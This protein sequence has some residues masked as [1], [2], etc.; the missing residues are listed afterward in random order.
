M[1]LQNESFVAEKERESEQKYKEYD[2][3]SQTLTCMTELV[4]SSV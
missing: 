2:D 3:Q 1:A 4:V